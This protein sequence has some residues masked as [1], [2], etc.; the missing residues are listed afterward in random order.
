MFAP[1]V[2]KAQTKEAVSSTPKLAPQRSMR[3]ARPFGGGAV[4][5]VG[6]GPCFPTHKS[7]CPVL[8][9]FFARGRGF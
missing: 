8:L 9:A 5:Q 1:P 6:A 7:G 2:A 4:G 3:V